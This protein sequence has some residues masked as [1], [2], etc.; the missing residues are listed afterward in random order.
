MK[1]RLK[2]SVA[3]MVFISLILGKEKFLLAGYTSA[4]IH[5]CTHLLVCIHLGV[6]P[7]KIVFAVSGMNLE[8]Q[9]VP[10]VKKHMLILLSGPVSSFA[11]YGTLFLFRKL[12]V[13][14]IPLLEFA[15]LCIG[16]INLF[17]IMPLDGGGMLRLFMQSRFGIISG[18][19]IMR[20]ISFALTF[21]FAFLCISLILSG[22]GN[23]F[24]ITFTLFVAFFGKSTKD[25]D[26][27]DTKEVL[28]SETGKNKRPK[29]FAFS[30]DA[31]LLDIASKISP[32][33]YLVGAIFS[34]GRF[35]G[36]ID[37]DFLLISIRSH[38]GEEKIEN[39]YNPVR[40]LG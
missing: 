7:Q 9:K 6:N 32:S 11:L 37:E 3:V 14:S 22:V 12:G 10:D 40:F 38:K 35:V 31:T 8:I 30:K 5:E 27:L 39:L 21:V 25:A 15:S 26:V 28:S 2:K 33:Y 18:I 17:P 1:I 29:Y 34:D 20:R 16:I 4:L 23:I 19:K 24:L 36:E 13:F